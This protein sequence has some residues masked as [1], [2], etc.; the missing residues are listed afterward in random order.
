M[1]PTSLAGAYSP[2]SPDTLPEELP[3][4]VLDAFFG[5]NATYKGEP[6][7]GCDNVATAVVEACEQVVAGTNYKVNVAA[8]C[9]NSAWDNGVETI[10]LSAVVFEPLPSSN[11][12]LEVTQVHR[13]GLIANT[14]DPQNAICPGPVTAGGWIPLS[15][16]ELPMEVADAAN[17]DLDGLLGN[18]TCTDQV[19]SERQICF[20]VV[21]GIGTEYDLQ[22][23][24][25]CTTGDIEGSQTVH[26]DTVYMLYPGPSSK[27]VLESI[28]VTPL[29]DA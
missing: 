24:I 29:D 22:L 16:S 3:L 15:L 11:K 14:V 7:T 26:V 12:P 23:T 1:S 8:V 17:S 25:A 10:F 27:P 4:A 13:D 9:N 20:N 21:D 18:S 28:T 6:F 19:V 5:T 2:V